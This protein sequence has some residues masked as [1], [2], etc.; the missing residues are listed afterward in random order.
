VVAEDLPAVTSRLARALQR[1][2]ELLRAEKREKWKRDL[3][4]PELVFDRWE[5]ARSLGFGEGSSIYHSS[6]VY[7]D[8]RVG[9][10]TWIGPNT[11]LDGSH[12]LTIGSYCSISAGVNI[13]SHDTVQWALSSG[14]LPAEGSPV[15]IG[16]CTHIGAQSVITRGVTIGDHVVIGASSFVNRDIPSWTVAVGVPCRPIGRVERRDGAY[17]L[18]YDKHI[19]QP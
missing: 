19:G 2:Y 14:Q 1:L 4:F 10:K 15:R 5:R 8:V 16:D 18:V 9:E 12:G 6:V 13:Y 3:P 7:G 17:Q 11:L